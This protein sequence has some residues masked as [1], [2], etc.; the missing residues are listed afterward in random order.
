VVGFDF[1]NVFKLI[2]Y[3]VYLEWDFVVFDVVYCW[4]MSVLF[5]V[6]MMVGSQLFGIFVEIDVVVDVGV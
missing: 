1:L 5:L 2:V 3:F 6:W 4:V